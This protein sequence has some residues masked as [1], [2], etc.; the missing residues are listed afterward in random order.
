MSICGYDRLVALEKIVQP[1]TGIAGHRRIFSNGHSQR[2]DQV[3]H[4]SAAPAKLPDAQREALFPRHFRDRLL[5]KIA[6]RLGR[7]RVEVWSTT[8]PTR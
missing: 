6:Q 2:H 4:L 8:L 7:S 5:A 1:I 3:W